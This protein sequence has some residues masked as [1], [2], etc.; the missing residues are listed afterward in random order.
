MAT[1]RPVAHK[2]PKGG[3]ITSGLKDFIEGDIIGVEIFWGTLPLP[4]LPGYTLVF[5]FP[6]HQKSENK[7]HSKASGSN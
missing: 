1:S 4:R 7:I 2:V 6:G 3:G 5:R